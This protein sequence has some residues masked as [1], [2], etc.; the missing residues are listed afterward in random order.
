MVRLVA[1]K[2]YVA[3]QPDRDY[4]GIAAHAFDEVIRCRALIAELCTQSST[5]QARILRGY[6]WLDEHSAFDP[7]YERARELIS[8]LQER[9][10]LIRWQL[11]DAE[12]AHMGHCVTFHGAWEYLDEFERAAFIAEHGDVSSIPQV[13]LPSYHRFMENWQALL[14]VREIREST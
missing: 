8:E 7:Q 3:R 2:D 4:A 9:H 13:H 14:T 5:I 6:A 12:V 11:R 1:G 10:S